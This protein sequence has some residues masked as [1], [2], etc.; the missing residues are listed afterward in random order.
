MLL[1]SFFE[2]AIFGMLQMLPLNGLDFAVAMPAIGQDHG[3]QP[4]FEMLAHFLVVFA[5][6]HL[7]YVR[8]KVRGNP[9]SGCVLQ[10]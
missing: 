4:S 5:R 8:R 7:S 1:F 2:P 10:S 9:S 3:L 6:N